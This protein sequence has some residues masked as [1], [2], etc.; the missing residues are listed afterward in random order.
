LKGQV[1]F[2]TLFIFVI[3]LTTAIFFSGM[4]IQTNEATTAEMLT[5]NAITEQAALQGEKIVI[6]SIFFQKGE[7]T[8]ITI[9]MF[10]KNPGKVSFNTDKIKELIESETTARNVEII[11]NKKAL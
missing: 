4:A 11:I 2:E 3:V 1:A 5:R 6:E 8:T 9:N 10:C 7:N